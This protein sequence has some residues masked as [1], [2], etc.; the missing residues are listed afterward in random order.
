MRKTGAVVVT[1]ASTGIG[2]A[3]A[4]RLDGLGF[5]VF[6][7]VRTQADAAKLKAKAS[8][9][10]ETVFLDVADALSIKASAEAVAAAV[11]G[12]GLAGLVNNAGIVIAGPME[13][14]PLDEFR[15]Q[16]DINV[17]GQLATTQA[18]LP[19]LRHARLPEG[20]PGRIVNVG[21]IGGRLSEPFLGAYS[22][23]KHALKEIGR[24]HV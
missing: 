22:A 13:V 16:M 18:F 24:A 8:G 7:G 1:G 20:I 5:D 21:S 12:N 9:K 15:L 14:L 17:T 4:L 2:E 19:L 10:L 11:G 3:C 23:S 6:A